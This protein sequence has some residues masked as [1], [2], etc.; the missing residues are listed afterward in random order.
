MGVHVSKSS[1]SIAVLTWRARRN[2]LRT[3]L[4]RLHKSETRR[5]PIMPFAVNANIAK[6]ADTRG[7]CAL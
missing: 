1:A 5:A 7:R 3:M 6:T 4:H 2:W